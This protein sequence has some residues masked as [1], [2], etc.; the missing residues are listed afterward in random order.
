MVNGRRKV[1]SVRGRTQQNFVSDGREVAIGIGQQEASVAPVLIVEVDPVGTL[2]VLEAANSANVD[3]CSEMKG[4][5]LQEPATSA[6]QTAP[7]V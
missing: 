7:E 5:G 6:R 2:S 3:C 1:G 4:T